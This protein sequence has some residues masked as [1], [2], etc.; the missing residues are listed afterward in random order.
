METDFFSV[1]IPLYNKEAFV[2]RCI[3]SVLSQTY[4]NFE[5]I[6]VNDGSTDHGWEKVKNIEDN[7][8]R[9]F[10]QTN[11]GVSIARNVGV[12]NATY[13]FVVFIDADDTWEAGFL[14]ELQNLITDFPH[15]GI[16][17]INHMYSYA[18][19]ENHYFSYTD[20]FEGAKRGIIDDYF[21]LFAKLERS[22]FS[23]SGCCFPK[24]IFNEVGGY[25]PGVKLT[26]DSDLWCRIAMRYP[27]SFSTI[28]LATY[29]VE[30]A[31]NTRTVMEY[32]EFQV[33]T[34][35]RSFFKDK[36]IS[37]S[38]KKSIAQLIAFGQL[39]LVRR[40]LLNNSKLFAM[41]MLLDRQLVVHYPKYVLLY[42][43]L[44][45]APNNWVIWMNKKIKNILNKR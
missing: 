15:A 12:K 9:L 42:P 3:H 36:A 18:D 30:T 17:G 41:K 27:V 34:T 14:E 33:I 29:F 32:K 31:N 10:S 2:E 5:I 11:A 24:H 28:P 8:I 1:I 6:V 37:K 19:R 22:P 43:F 25:K 40:A 44:A 20:L 38:R 39:S 4:P 26:E 13:D 16:Y 21:G 23:N 35:L 45:L 7:R